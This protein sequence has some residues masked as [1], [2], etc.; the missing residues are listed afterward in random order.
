M[1]HLIV[2]GDPGIRKGAIIEYEGEELH[3]FS[4]NRQGDY[5]GPEEVQ[6]W[7][8]VGAEDELE[9]YRKRQYVPYWLDVESIDADAVNVKKHG[10]DLT[11]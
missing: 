1:F 2:H 5:H 3:C 8:T 11:V 9:T 7:C 6:L 4:V 10:G